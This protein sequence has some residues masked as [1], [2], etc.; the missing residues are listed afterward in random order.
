MFNEWE[1]S[2]KMEA[3]GCVWLQ[4]IKLFS[5]ILRWDYLEQMTFQLDR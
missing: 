2:E 1:R 4:E 3:E 5:N